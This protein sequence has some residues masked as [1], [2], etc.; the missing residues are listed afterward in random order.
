MSK[1]LSALLVLVLGFA[2]VQPCYGWQNSYPTPLPVTCSRCYGTHNFLAE[3]ALAFL[4]YE[5]AYFWLEDTSRSIPTSVFASEEYL[6]GTQ[7]PDFGGPGFKADWTLHAVYYSSDG[8]LVDDYAARRAQEYYEQVQDLLKNGNFDLAA[9][10]MGIV[11]HYV[12]D[13]TSYWHVMGKGN[14][15]LKAARHGSTYENWVKEETNDYTAPF[16]SCL[17]F[18]GKLEQ[19]SAYDITLKLA[20]DTTFDTSGSGRTAKWMDDKYSPTWPYYR[21]R[22]CQSLNLAVNGLADLIFSAVQVRSETTA[23]TPM[24]TVT[25]TNQPIVSTVTVGTT[26]L[27]V[28]TATL[29]HSLTLTVKEQSFP[30]FAT[31]VFTAS[32]LIAGAIVIS[33]LLLRSGRRATAKSP[34]PDSQSQL[35]AKAGVDSG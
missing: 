34:S 21:E 9:R 3:H 25:T 16:A 19:V 26:S 33:S 31:T 29:T 5:P 28:S 12:T 7:I 10:Y 20:Y 32:L 4:P 14:E 8:S 35:G 23:T 24:L 6:Y 17:G 15:W 22:V 27:T 30:N 1:V 2:V 13:V 11:S 18:D